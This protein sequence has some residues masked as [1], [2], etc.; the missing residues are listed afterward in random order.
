M[1]N[2]KLIKILK[3]LSAEEFKRLRKTVQSPLFTTSPNIFKLYQALRPFFPDFDHSNLNKFNVYAKVF[4]TKPYKDGKMR[5]LM[6]EMTQIVEEFLI[7]L[8]LEQQKFQRQELL[9]RIYGKRNLYSFFEKQTFQLINE[10]ESLP[11]RDA[12]YYWH[13]MELQRHYF[14]HPITPKIGKD[15][16]LLAEVIADLDNYYMM[17]KLRLACD[18]VSRATYLKEEHDIIFLQ[19]I[20]AELKQ[21]EDLPLSYKTYLTLIDLLEKQE[22][23]S[24]WKTRKIF[25]DG[26]EQFSRVDKSTIL[27]YLFNFAIA[28]VTRGENVFR[29]ENFELYKFALEQGLLIE[30]NTI[31][32]IAFTNIASYGASLH[33]FEWTINFIEEN[34]KYLAKAVKKEA[35][36]LSLAFVTFFQQNY[37]QTIDILQPIIF[38]KLSHNR[39]SK[40]LLLRSYFELSLV[41]E[42][43]LELFFSFV[44][45]FQK[46][47]YRNNIDSGAKIQSYLNLIK[48]LKKIAALVNTH[49]WKKTVKE[50]MIREAE[51]EN[52]VLKPWFMKRV[53]EL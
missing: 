20:R 11:Y 1:N 49:E 38:H 6:T 9:T 22:V 24:Y 7:F 27:H 35:T 36:Q 32:D 2:T 41:N 30:N 15:N 13:K 10:L 12:N 23:A 3:V 51:S 43:Y 46:S 40:S 5:K 31:S 45:A 33:Q 21:K 44:A 25:F 34:K 39:R 48:Y 14:S 16:H 4:A 37:S 17:V 28:Q 50:E 42:S 52:M 47:L 19:S 29:I 18:V 53:K 8:E 26:I